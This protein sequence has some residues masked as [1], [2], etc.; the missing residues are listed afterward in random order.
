MILLPL[1]SC[2]LKDKIKRMQGINTALS[3]EFNHKNVNSSYHFGSEENDNY[4]QINFYN[5]ELSNKTHSELEN[6]ATNI[7]AFFK[8]GYPEY[9]DLDFIEVRFR[10]SDLSTDD[11]Y[12]NFKF[13]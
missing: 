7:Q 9:D 2:S 5:Y 1:L 11:S 8:K 4:F 3:K 6:T 13:K 10:K 12:V